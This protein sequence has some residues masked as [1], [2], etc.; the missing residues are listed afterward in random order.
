[1]EGRKKSEV[2]CKGR[3]I[4]TG[5]M[6]YKYYQYS[7]LST[8]RIYKMQIV[9]KRMFLNIPNIHLLIIIE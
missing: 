5:T 9:S 3:I 2:D 8:I 1:M 4:R 7:N 6:I